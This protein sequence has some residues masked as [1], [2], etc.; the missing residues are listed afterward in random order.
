VDNSCSAA[1]DDGVQVV[2]HVDEKGIMTRLG[3][4]NTNN[5]YNNNKQPL[6]QHRVRVSSNH[7]N[8]QPQQ[9]QIMPLYSSRVNY[10]YFHDITQQSTMTNKYTGGVS[11]GSGD[12]GGSSGGGGG[13]GDI[14]VV[15]R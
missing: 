8:K 11:G 10:I 1:T 6:Q 2:V 4:E 13:S 15:E 14:K 7:N 5:N 12:G 9:I 3:E